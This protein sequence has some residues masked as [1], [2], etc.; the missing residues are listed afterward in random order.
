MAVLRA[1]SLS[2]GSISH[3]VPDSLARCEAGV[4]GALETKLAYRCIHPNVPNIRAF[5]DARLR[6]F[7]DADCR[8]R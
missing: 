5:I 8:K 2:R 6:L 3:A 1:D 7:T 4:S